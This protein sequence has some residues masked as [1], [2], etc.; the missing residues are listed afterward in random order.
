[1]GRNPCCPKEGM[2]KGAWT[3][4]EDQILSDYIKAHGEGKWRNIPKEAGLKRCGKSCRLRWLNY[5]RPDIKRGNISQEEE[6]LIL[7]LHRLLGNRWAL[8]A[9][10]L[11]GRTDNEIK[12]YWNT[13]LGKRAK[14]DQSMGERKKTKGGP[15]V[16]TI[17]STTVESSFVRSKAST[18]TDLENLDTMVEA[19]A[20]MDGDSTTNAAEKDNSQKFTT[21]EFNAGELLLSDILDSD[22]WE[23]YQFDNGPSEEGGSN[24]LK[25]CGKSCR[26]RWLNYLR[27][28]IKRGSISLEEEDLIIR[29]HRLLGNRW[30]LIA[31]R[32]PGR[33]DNEIKNYWNSTLKKK[34]EADRSKECENEEKPMKKPFMAKEIRCTDLDTNLAGEPFVGEGL[35]TN[36]VGE[37][38]SS[39]GFLPCGS[40]NL[41]DFIMDSNIEFG[42]FDFNMNICDGG[43]S[44]SL[45]Q[46]LF[47]EEMLKSWAG[48]DMI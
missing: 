41:W 48:D 36:L 10:R 13:T 33:T 5:L 43:L 7:R 32:L 3:A 35:A 38:K 8:I 1:M 39:D 6:D 34:V 20:S 23:Q 24:G 25:R 37:T 45:E 12:N 4:L 19:E 11:P 18:C 40:D 44:S 15:L 26:L 21:D 30:S 14:N 27:P 47:L 2:N 17:P 28:G 42:E 22:L 9:G 16:K 46:P 29:L 31:G